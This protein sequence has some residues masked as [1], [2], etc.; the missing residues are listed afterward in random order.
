M[1]TI[2]VL[3]I[4]IGI[5]LLYFY[6]NQQEKEGFIE[7]IK[8][9]KNLWFV[10][11]DQGVNTRRWTDFGSRS[12]KDLNLPFL[13]I[14]K[15][16]CHIT[17]GADFKINELIGRQAVAQVIRENKGHVPDFHLDIPP[18]LWKAW[19]RAALLA[20]AGGLYLDG[21]SL[22][23]GPSFASVIDSSDN[24]LF[25]LDSNPLSVGSYAGWALRDRSEPWLIYT[26]TIVRFIEKGQLSWD[27]AKSKNLVASWNRSI[28]SNIKVIPESEWS[29]LSDG[30]PIELEDLFGRSL[31]KYYSPT[32]KSIYVPIDIEKLKRSVTY[33][34]F[35]RMSS[36]QIMDP[37]SLFIWA[38]LTD[39]K[40][41]I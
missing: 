24:L 13:Q 15:A 25:G 9:N 22:C 38:Q 12:S 21:Y 11:D 2:I 23:L 3:T 39:P 8:G 6:R 36:E 30:T 34:W 27:S 37:D 31:S 35:L 17:Q 7:N 16:R 10:I 5:G 14:T 26:D 19:A 40:R 33:K 28:L 18:Y 32:N 41:T 4:L 1:D 20:Y 29:R